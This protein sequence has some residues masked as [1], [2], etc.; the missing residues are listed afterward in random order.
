MPTPPVAVNDS[1]STDQGTPLTVAAPGVLSNDT[2]PQGKALTA[3]LVS[4]PDKGT[5]TLN[6][7]GSFTYT[8]VAN[9]VGSDSFTYQ[10]NDGSQTSGT[11]NVTITILPVNSSPVTVDPPPPSVGQSS[12]TLTGTMQVGFTITIT[13]SGDATIGPVVNASSTTWSCLISNLTS[14][15]N[16]FTVTA[17]S[18][19]GQLTTTT[20]TVN[21]SA[22]NVAPVPALTRPAFFILAAGL[23]LLILFANA[24]DSKKKKEC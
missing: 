16:V 19:S 8:P 9:Y 7:D 20:V 13:S 5:L 21:Y 3:Q 11:A 4:G 15:N 23:F 10:A 18:P 24:H 6:T 12:Y 22:S 14:G 2:D 17:T 1:Y